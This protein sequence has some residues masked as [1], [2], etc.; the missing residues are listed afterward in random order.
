[1][2]K[3]KNYSQ[4]IFKIHPFNLSPWNSCDSHV[5]LVQPGSGDTI[6]TWGWE[7]C[8]KVGRAGMDNDLSMDFV[9]FLNPFF[10]SKRII[11]E[12]PVNRLVIHVKDC[13]K[14][15]SGKMRPIFYPFGQIFG[16][17]RKKGKSIRNSIDR[18]RIVRNNCELE[19]KSNF[20]GIVNCGY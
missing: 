3:K 10:I 15:Y 4:P 11:P 12:A 19:S 18:A 2:K 17:K 6:D 9:H 14:N 16:N 8:S 7:T 1:M 13:G 20:S 5:S